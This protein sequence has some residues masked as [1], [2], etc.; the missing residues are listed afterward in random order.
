MRHA[1]YFEAGDNDRKRRVWCGPGL[2]VGQVNKKSNVWWSWKISFNVRRTTVLTVYRNM[3]LYVTMKVRDAWNTSSL[4]GITRDRIK[5]YSGDG[6]EGNSVFQQ[7]NTIRCSSEGRCQNI[8]KNMLY[9][10]QEC[11][12]IYIFVSSASCLIQASMYKVLGTLV[13]G[14]E[15]VGRVLTGSPKSMV[16]ASNKVWSGRVNFAGRGWLPLESVLLEKSLRVAL[17]LCICC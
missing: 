9:W 13:L 1:K 3:S 15:L 2:V 5:K 6:V 12:K 10:V 7:A 11:R 4:N 8:S 14:L 16:E 17:I